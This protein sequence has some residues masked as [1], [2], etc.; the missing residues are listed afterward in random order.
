MRTLFISATLLFACAFSGFL[1]CRNNDF[2]VGYHFDEPKKV[3]FIQSGQQD[4]HHPVMMLELSRSAKMLLGVEEPNSIAVMGRT[5]TALFGTGICLLLFLMSKPTLGER[6]SLMVMCSIAVMPT[7][8]VHSH[9]LKEDIYLTFFSF[10]SI[11]LF[12]HY[13]N[14][15]DSGMAMIT[16]ICFGLAIATH[17]KGLLLLLLF[18]P[19]VC[20]HLF[21]AFKKTLVHVVVFLVAGMLTFCVVNICLFEDPQLFF[22]G[23]KHESHHIIQGHWVPIYWYDFFLAYH[24]R[25]SLIPGMTAMF[26]FAGVFAFAFYL[27][28]IGKLTEM[29]KLLIVFGFISYFVPEIS[30]LKPNPD[31]GRYVI[32]VVPV[33]IYFVTKGVSELACFLAKQKE[34]SL[35]YVP[36]WALPTGLSLLLI[37]PLV[38]TW[39]LTDGLVNDT[40]ELAWAFCEKE[41]IEA[42]FELMAGKRIEGHYAYDLTLDELRLAGKTHL[43]CSSFSYQPFEMTKGLRHDPTTKRRR[44]KYEHWFTGTIHEFKAA[45][46]SF[47]FSNPT[48]KLIDLNRVQ[49]VKRQSVSEPSH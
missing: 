24:L 35:I 15:R 41:G 44:E 8:V 23:L 4:F 1:N 48:L 31:D 25:Y 33:L 42:E 14:K 34:R 39:L 6:W 47:A 11:Y 38:D 49:T 40:R 27:S 18:F 36:I 3:R 26:A 46:R 28:Q 9:Y 10:A 16:G 12:D 13:L 17:Y 45:Y 5:I 22:R 20:R 29:E 19:W 43:I 7:I 37:V 30:P 32:P 21:C 2:P